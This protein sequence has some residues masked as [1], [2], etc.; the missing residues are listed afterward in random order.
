MTSSIVSRGSRKPRGEGFDPDRAAAVE[1]GDHREIA[2]VHRVEPETVDLEPVERAVGDFGVDPVVARRMGE[3]AHPAEQP[4]GDARGAARA[5]G[6]FV[7]AVLGDVGAEQAG[8]AA[9]DLLQ[10]RRRCRN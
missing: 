2:A 4:A 5:A 8:G 9:D 6:D 1:V 7:R 3:I 10:V